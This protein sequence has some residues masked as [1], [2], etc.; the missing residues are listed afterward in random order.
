[1]ARSHLTPFRT[2]F[3]RRFFPLAAAPG[4]FLL[5]VVTGVPLIAAV[6]LSF[7]FVVPGTF[8]FHWVGLVNYQGHL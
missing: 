6:F 2:W 3:D 4:F 1:M 5:V 7:T 8:S